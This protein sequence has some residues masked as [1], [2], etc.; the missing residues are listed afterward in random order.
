[1]S[2]EFDNRMA[3]VSPVL[4]EYLD[5]FGECFPWP[6]LVGDLKEAER[7]AA[8]CIRSGRPTELGYDLDKVY[9]AGPREL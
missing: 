1:M 9:S 7:Q 6:W 4:Q 2:G 8:Q 3:D 5:K